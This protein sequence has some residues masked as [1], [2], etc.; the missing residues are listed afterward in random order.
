MPEANIKTVQ[1]EAL[2]E[3]RQDVINH[4]V[5]RRHLVLVDLERLEDVEAKRAKLVAQREL[6]ERDLRA[7]GWKEPEVAKPAE[8]V[9][10]AQLPSVAEHHP[11]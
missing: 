4:L 8:D 1:Q 3:H 6:L 9:D 2:G 11:V 7:L 10:L 5:N